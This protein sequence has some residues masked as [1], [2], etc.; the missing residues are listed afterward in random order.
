MVV[1]YNKVFLLV[2][3]TKQKI[4][5]KQTEK[6]KTKSR[7]PLTPYQ[8]IADRKMLKGSPETTCGRQVS[9]FSHFKVWV[10]FLDYKLTGQTSDVLAQLWL[11]HKCCWFNKQTRISVSLLMFILF[12]FIEFMVVKIYKSC[13]LWITTLHYLLSITFALILFERLMTINKCS[14][15]FKADETKTRT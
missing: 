4:V 8:D 3:V 14:Y 5:S 10:L 13:W 7:S 1:Y 2:C 15:V 6:I 9:S 11:R 12:L